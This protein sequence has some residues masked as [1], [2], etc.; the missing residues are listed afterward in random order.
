MEAVDDLHAWL[1]RLVPGTIAGVDRKRSPFIGSY[2]CEHLV[3]ELTDGTSRRFF[4]KDF[5]RSRQTKDERAR[6][7]D[8]ER[9]VYRD[10]L[11]GAEL[12]TPAYVGSIWDDTRGR[13]W[14]LLELVEAEVVKET[15]IRYGV[16]AA[17]WLA[18]MQ[19]H[20]RRHADRL[21]AADFLIRHDA[22]YFSGKA[23]A[24]RRDVAAIEPS[25]VG[26]LEDALADYGRIIDVLT[27][28]PQS[29]VHGGYIPWHL[30]VDERCEPARVCVIDWELAARGGT[31]HDLAYFADGAAPAIEQTLLDTYRRA[32]AEHGV[33]VPDHAEHVMACVRLHRVIDWLSRAVE[34]SFPA[35][36]T[37]SLVSDLARAAARLDA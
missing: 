26:R 36:K 25:C 10:L 29:L 16:H 37:A 19:A 35:S 24:A 2:D 17:A 18:R 7:R 31:L 5:G 8:R 11:A 9:R 13:Y 28:Q 12:G 33:A 32:A 30:I 22:A 27:S 6:R 23:A 21:E 4:L 3:V 15:D 20:F 34:K 14:L 1:E